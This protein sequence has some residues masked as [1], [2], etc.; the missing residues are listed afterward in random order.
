MF[1]YTY[2]LRSLKDGKLYVG[3]TENLKRRFKEHNFGYVKATKNRRP[4]VLIYYEACA[5]KDRSYKREMYF[6]TGFGKGFLK[7]R[8]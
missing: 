6:K 4:F 3:S 1:F 2:V 7:N 5:N 8:I